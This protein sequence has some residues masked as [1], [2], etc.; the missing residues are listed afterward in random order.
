MKITFAPSVRWDPD[1]KSVQ[2]HVAVDDKVIP[3]VIAQEYLTFPYA[4]LLSGQQAIDLFHRQ[5]SRIEEDVR[6]CVIREGLRELHG[7]TLRP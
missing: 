4:E 7:F 1:R 6:E 2:C 5:R 3:C